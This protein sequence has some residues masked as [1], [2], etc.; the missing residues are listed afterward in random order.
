[1]AK[2]DWNKEWDMEES[3]VQAMIASFEA[4]KNCDHDWHP[5]GEEEAR[6]FSEEAEECKKCGAV[7]LKVTAAEF[8]Q[9][10]E[11]LE[12]GHVGRSTQE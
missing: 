1:M 8:E 10:T 11:A 2:V 3:E 9:I 6:V 12:E 4:M 5:V 7:Q